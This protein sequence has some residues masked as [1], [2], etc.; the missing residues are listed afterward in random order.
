MAG[1]HLCPDISYVVGVLVPFIQ[2]PNE[3]HQEGE[4][5]IIMYLNNTKNTWL[6]FGGE[7]SK[8]AEGF[9]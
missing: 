5:C 9:L 3:S 1:D 4:K 2:D 6:T 8:L 7:S